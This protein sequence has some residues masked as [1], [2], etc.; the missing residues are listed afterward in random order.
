METVIIGSGIAGLTVSYVLKRAGIKSHIIEKESVPGGLSKSFSIDGV[1]FDMGGHASFA[2]DTF[3]RDILENEVSYNTQKAVAYNYKNGKWIKHPAQIN[4]AVLDTTEKVLV[5]ADYF[6]RPYYEHPANYMEWLISQYGEYFAYNYPKLYTQKYWT[7]EPEQLET[8]W[9]GIRMYQPTIEEV[10]YGAFEKNTKE[11]HYSGEIRYPKRGGFET[12]IKNLEED[13]SVEYERNI[14]EIDVNRKRISFSEGDAEQYD[15]LV[16]TAPLPE[17]IPLIKNVPEEIVSV[18]RKL[19]ATSL[20]LVSI[21]IDGKLNF[22]FSPAF[23]IY[24]SDIPAT[25]VYSTTMYSGEYDG[26]TAL[27]AEVFISKFR[28]LEGTLE[29]IRDRVINQL[30]GIGMFDLDRVVGKDVRFEKY[31][32]IIFTHDIYENRE[33]IKKYLDDNYIESAGRFGE[34]DYLW[35]D[36]AMLSGKRVADRIVDRVSRNIIS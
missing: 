27:Q 32:N 36:Q 22:E 20:I 1:W 25:R 31:A 2:K 6:K 16:N 23:Y 4:L 7:V 13:A 24:D 5:M 3:V 21:C 11:V 12:F 33:K 28:S 14:T 15:V 17:I 30:A 34:W 8:K 19:N 26:Y 18:S 9:V 35:T 29:E 10:L